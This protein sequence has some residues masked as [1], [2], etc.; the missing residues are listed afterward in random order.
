MNQLLNYSQVDDGD[1]SVAS[2]EEVNVF[3]AG[4]HDKVSS[5]IKDLIAHGQKLGSPSKE[6]ENSVGEEEGDVPDVLY[7][8]QYR[9]VR[10]C[11]VDSKSTIYRS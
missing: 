8:V 9:D 4:S 7:V 5:L 1:S 3:K 2:F 10:G 11:V 6:K